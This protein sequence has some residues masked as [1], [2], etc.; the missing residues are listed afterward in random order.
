M[1]ITFVGVWV[2]LISCAHLKGEKS[3]D[4]NYFDI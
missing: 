1:T 2:V 3:H 4:R